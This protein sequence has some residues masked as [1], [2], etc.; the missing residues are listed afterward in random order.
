MITKQ[1][2]DRGC[3]HSRKGS[4]MDHRFEPGQRATLAVF[5]LWSLGWK[6]VSLW[7]AAR[8]GSKTWYAAL[9]LANTAGILDAIYVF[10]FSSWG[11]ARRSR[12]EGVVSGHVS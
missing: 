3:R 12:R 7:H 4:G 9:L 10:R 5:V 2:T 1:A 11:R 8:D 6:A